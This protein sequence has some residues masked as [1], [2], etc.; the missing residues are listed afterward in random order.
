M[1]PLHPA[2][3]G[4]C[5]GS[6]KCISFLQLVHVKVPGPVISPVLYVRASLTFFPRL[7]NT[8]DVPSNNEETRSRKPVPT[9]VGSSCLRTCSDQ[10]RKST[11]VAWLS[12]TD[13]YAIAWFLSCVVSFLSVL[14]VRFC[15]Q[16]SDFISVIDR[17]F[18]PLPQ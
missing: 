12:P 10:R 2:Q 4:T 5:L 16:T 8:P 18:A 17:T 6:S 13:R 11:S 3:G 1:V 15:G 7:S 14:I 9:R